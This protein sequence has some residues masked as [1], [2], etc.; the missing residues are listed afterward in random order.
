MNPWRRR[1]ADPPRPDESISLED[2][3]WRIGASEVRPAHYDAEEAAALAAA[4]AQG[5]GA[6]PADAARTGAG[7]SGAAPGK[8]APRKAAKA[9]AAGV[10]IVAPVLQPRPL[11]R[12]AHTVRRNIRASGS[13]DG[14]G[15]DRGPRRLTLWRDM[16]ALLFGVVA[17][18]LIAQLALSN[19]GQT[20]VSNHTPG[21]TVA[22]SEVAVVGTPTKTPAPTAAVTLGPVVNPSLIPVILATPTPMPVVTAAPTRAPTPR[23]TIPTVTPRPT[24]RPVVTPRP[25]AV[26]TPTP[27]PNPAVASITCDTPIGLSVTCHDHSVNAKAGSEVWSS[28]G[29]YSVVSGGN[30]KTFVTLG[31]SASGSYTITLRVTGAGGNVSTDSAV[32]GL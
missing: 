5:I 9:D 20:A 18:A 17:I 24:T 23:P 29:S 22:P 8:R 3:A 14:A 31:Y 12:P 10:P 27:T 28:T 1:P 6:A 11:I 19:G 25:T 7:T 4:E 32:V 16:S 30:G 21:Q 15:A 26:P 13:A 2:I